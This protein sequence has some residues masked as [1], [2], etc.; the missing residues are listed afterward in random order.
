MNEY[1][2]FFILTVV[3][4]FIN[5]CIGRYYRDKHPDGELQVTITDKERK[6]ELI[7]YKH[8]ETLMSKKVVTFKVGCV[9]DHQSE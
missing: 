5:Y 3:T 7:Y 4:N 8:P 2:I 1:V 6:W 9:T